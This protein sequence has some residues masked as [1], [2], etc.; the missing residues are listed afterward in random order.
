MR[1][2]RADGRFV[3]YCGD[4]FFLGVVG[5]TLKKVDYSFASL[6]GLTVWSAMHLAGG[7]LAVG[8]KIEDGVDVLIGTPGRYI[9]YFKQGVFNIDGT[10]VVIL[11]EADRLVEESGAMAFR[12]LVFEE[13]AR[14]TYLAGDV[15]R[16]RRELQDALIGYREYSAVGHVA[17]L[18]KELGE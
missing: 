12:P 2:A 7:G 16:A 10:Q 13:R 3:L 6:V 8:R 4:V 9:D 14:M 1:H 17:R 11:D 15:D 5:V 18:V